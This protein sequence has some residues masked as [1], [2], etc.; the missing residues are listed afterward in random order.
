MTTTE[1]AAAVAL[2][3]RAPSADAFA[4]L[5]QLV[6]REKLRAPR[7]VAKF[8]ALLLQKHAWGLGSDGASCSTSVM[9]APRDIALIRYC[10]CCCCC[11]AEQCGRSTSRC[12][13]R[14]W[15]CTTS[16]SRR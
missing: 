8:G 12:S 14:R 2:A 1:L 15:T 5:L 4:Q 9:V 16:S 6:R 10:C 7:E 11:W 3:E 13:W